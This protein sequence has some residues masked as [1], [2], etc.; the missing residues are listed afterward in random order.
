M[1]ENRRP[2]SKD[3]PFLPL[4]DQVSDQIVRAL[5]NYR[6]MRDAASEA[7]FLN[8]YGS[9]LL[10][11]LVGLGAPGVQARLPRARDE[12]H[13]ALVAR[14]IA[15]IKARVNQGGELEALLRILIHVRSDEG[16]AD[17]RGFQVIRK[18]RQERPD[19]R[20]RPLSQLRE[21]IKEQVFLMQLDEDR[22]LA[23]LPTL[24]PT[25]PER[26]T[27]LDIVRRILEAHGPCMRTNSHVCA[28]WR[29]GLALK[30]RRRHWAGAK[31]GRAG[32]V[33]D[34]TGRRFPDALGWPRRTTQGKSP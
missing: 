2:A 4:Q 1:R 24:L 11:A 3:N 6:D 33:T 31:P 29:C 27:A 19:A 18:L 21:I 14:R 22:A 7:L 25:E 20:S 32:N 10:Q 15:D 13:E 12:A 26:R 16:G 9:P 23:A 8:L 5:D 28:R 17:E 34:R 30:D